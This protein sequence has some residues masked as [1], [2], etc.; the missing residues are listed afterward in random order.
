MAMIDYGAIVFKNGKQVNHN[1]FMDMKEAVGW[2]DENLSG[3][4]CGPHLSGNYF[5]Y[6]GDKDLVIAFYKN[7]FTIVTIEYE[8]GEQILSKKTEY[9]SDTPYSWWKWQDYIGD[10][11][12][13]VTK[14]NGYYIMRWTYK[15][16]RY[17]VYFGY[18]VDVN[19]FDKYHIVNYYRSIPFFLQKTTRKIKDNLFD[20]WHRNIQPFYKKILAAFSGKHLAP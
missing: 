2:S 9:L 8:H 10:E 13:T 11:K 20:L 18:G 16:N 17:K 3:E 4:S 5:A 6:I 14:R 1:M 19:C 7:L 15:E 12:C